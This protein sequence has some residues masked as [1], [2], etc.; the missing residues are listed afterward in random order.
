MALPGPRIQVAIRL[1]EFFAQARPVLRAAGEAGVTVLLEP[2]PK[3]IVYDQPSIE[4]AP[5][6]RLLC[7]KPS[8][9]E[10]SGPR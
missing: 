6:P 8:C 9:G 1:A 2:H 10:G 5:A 3:Q 7:R 4:A